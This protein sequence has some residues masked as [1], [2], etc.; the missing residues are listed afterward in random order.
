[1]E[2]N[3]FICCQEQIIETN[4]G[5]SSP[6]IVKTSRFILKSMLLRIVTNFLTQTT[7][8]QNIVET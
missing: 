1:M 7:A 4:L 3:P 2:K 8:N 6:I 5:L